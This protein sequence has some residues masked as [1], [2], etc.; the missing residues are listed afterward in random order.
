[1]VTQSEKKHTGVPVLRRGAGRVG[2]FEATAA[3]PTVGASTRSKVQVSRTQ[4]RSAA[5]A[6]MVSTN[7]KQFPGPNIGSFAIVDLYFLGAGHKYGVRT[8]SHGVCSELRNQARS[9]TSRI[10]ESAYIAAM[11]R[12]HVKFVFRRSSHYTRGKGS[13]V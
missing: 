6:L 2:I 13:V 3:G 10:P 4:D 1:M 8:H 11:V 12:W 7:I 9:Q 5:T